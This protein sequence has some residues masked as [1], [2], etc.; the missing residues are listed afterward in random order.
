VNG[1]CVTR[2]IVALLVVSGVRAAETADFASGAEAI[3]P[4]GMLAYE[5]SLATLRQGLALAWH[6]G[7][8]PHSALWLRF[9][10]EAGRPRGDALQL[11]DARA[12]AYEPDLQPGGKGLA[13]AWYEK[14]PDSGA[15]TAWL[16]GLD[17]QG[18]VL[19]RHALSG[20]GHEGRNP[21]VRAIGRE[22]AVAWIE[23]TSGT[24]PAIWIQRFDARG[25]NRDA[26]RRV[27]SAST[28]TWNLNAAV[29]AKG[30][31]F[32]VYDAAMDS[33]ASEV[34]WARVDGAR[35]QSGR[36]RA[37]DGMASTYPDVAIEGE[38]LAIAWTETRNGGDDISLF[39]GTL[40]ELAHPPA[41]SIRHVTHS[42]SATSVYLAWNSGRLELAWQEGRG[43]TTEIHAQRFS[44][45]GRAAAQPR[46]LTHAGLQSL[47][48]SIQRWHKDFA[49]AWNEYQADPAD[50]AHV[51]PLASVARLLRVPGDQR[52]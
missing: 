19:W 18:Q 7:N 25:R 4:P 14:Q 20:P 30:G 22:L 42:G 48:P 11:T 27:A 6:G 33:R 50:A 49:I 13:V 24:Q 21:V 45:D 2:V 9:I 43:G 46:Q 12:D 3:S 47:T 40:A 23:T 5:V 37:D 31:L 38:L 51:R 17:A 36:L 1:P 15:L 26:P 16:A 35:I 10:D 32:L 44:A 8:L 39:S 28:T 41:A 34:H 52:R 29:D